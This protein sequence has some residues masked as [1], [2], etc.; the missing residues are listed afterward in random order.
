MI[1]LLLFRDLCRGAVPFS[2]GD[3]LPFPS[4]NFFAERGE[5]GDD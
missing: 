1:S 3:P 4:L 2:F 5:G